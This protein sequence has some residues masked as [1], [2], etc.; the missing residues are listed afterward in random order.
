LKANPEAEPGPLFY[1]DVQALLC[2]YPWPGNVRELRNLVE[3]LS[4]LTEGFRHVPDDVAVG[5]RGELRL[6]DGKENGAAE[7]DPE[8][9]SLR[10]M[11]TKWLERIC[12]ASTLNKK[13]LAKRLG[14]SRTTLWKRTRKG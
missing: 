9:F 6:S 1:P 2:G 5:I 13:D 10:E 4:M 14:V 8:A 3:R 11:E 7:R 12:G